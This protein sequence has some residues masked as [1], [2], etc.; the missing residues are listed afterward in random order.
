MYKATA[1]ITIS[2][3]TFDSLIFLGGRIGVGLVITLFMGYGGIGG[4]EWRHWLEWMLPFGGCCLGNKVYIGQSHGVFVLWMGV[5][6]LHRAGMIDVVKMTRFFMELVIYL[7]H[8][9]VIYSLIF[10]S[11]LYTQPREKVL[12]YIQGL[13]IKGGR[14]MGPPIFCWARKSLT[15]MVC[16][17]LVLVIQLICFFWSLSSFILQ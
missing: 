13:Q 11:L 17:K 15:P 6:T 1:Q 14:D 2:V 5:K 16:N 10:C 12:F 8:C 4:W 9:C 3:T 7:F